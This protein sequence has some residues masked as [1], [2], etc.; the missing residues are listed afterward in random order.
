MTLNINSSSNY[1]MISI[2]R[3]LFEEMDLPTE[4]RMISEDAISRTIERESSWT[5]EINGMN[6]FPSGKALGSG[7]SLIHSNG[8]SLSIWQGVFTTS[9][10]EQISFKGRDVNKN[11][12]F[13]VLRTYFTPSPELSW[14]DGLVCFVEGHFDSKSNLFRCE[15]FEL[16]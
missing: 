15:G 7:K 4:S 3:K 11:G 16:M 9:N 13:V 8:I 12:K 6:Q 5:A 10:G 1:D 14:I 2:G